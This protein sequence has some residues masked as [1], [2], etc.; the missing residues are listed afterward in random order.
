MAT[1]DHDPYSVSIRVIAEPKSSR[2]D[3]EIE[4]ISQFGSTRNN[5]ASTAAALNVDA[6]FVRA[7]ASYT[8][9]HPWKPRIS[10][11]YDRDSGDGHRKNTVASTSHSAASCQPGPCWDSRSLHCIFLESWMFEKLVV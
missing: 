10:N 3:F 4:E 8:F 9:A 7:V 5:L 2:V 1:R 11:E 6:W